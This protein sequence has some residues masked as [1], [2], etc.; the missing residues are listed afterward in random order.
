[1]TTGSS[2]S[3]SRYDDEE[4]I[5]NGTVPLTTETAGL[6]IEGGRHR[7]RCVN[8]LGI[9]PLPMTTGLYEGK[10]DA[11]NFKLSKLVR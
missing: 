3:I 9:V 11:K 4:H 2:R 6:Y 1:M 10:E 7:Q 5:E 8:I